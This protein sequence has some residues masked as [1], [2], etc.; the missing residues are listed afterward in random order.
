LKWFLSAYL[1]VEASQIVVHEADLDAL[2]IAV[3][4]LVMA[5]GMVKTLHEGCPVLDV[6]DKRELEY[7]NR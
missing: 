2:S 1:V 7:L 5:Y 6:E 3:M 4:L